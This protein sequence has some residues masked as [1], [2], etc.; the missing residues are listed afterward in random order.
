VKVD[1]YA[2]KVEKSLKDW[3]EKR[4]R[5]VKWVATADAAL[6]VDEPRLISMLRNFT[7]RAYKR[8]QGKAQT[9]GAEKPDRAATRLAVASP[10]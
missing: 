2:L 4:H 10:D 7:C 1:V 9:K 6:L 3:P 5:A 8:A